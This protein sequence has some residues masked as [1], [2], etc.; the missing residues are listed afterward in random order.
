MSVEISEVPIES[1]PSQV[2][3]DTSKNDNDKEEEKQI[4]EKTENNEN[5]DPIISDELDG[6]KKMMNTLTRVRKREAD[7]KAQ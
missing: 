6:S 1:E 3:E 2:S 7:P 4:F 5:G